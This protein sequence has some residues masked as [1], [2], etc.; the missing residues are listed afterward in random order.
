[1]LIYRP[2]D[3]GCGCERSSESPCVAVVVAGSPRVQNKTLAALFLQVGHQL[4]EAR[5]PYRL[6]VATPGVDPTPQ[7]RRSKLGSSRPSSRTGHGFEVQP[8]ILR[9]P[10]A[11]QRS[12]G[13]QLVG[14][15]DCG[16][17][18][19]GASGGLVNKGMHRHGGI[20]TDPVYVK[21]CNLKKT[22]HD[23]FLGQD[24][25]DG[26]ALGEEREQRLRRFPFSGCTRS[27]IP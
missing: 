12:G 17:Q 23:M 9:T 3:A 5:L 11:L 10:Q 20:L 6:R 1:M 15:Q 22:G 26:L 27:N 18:Q 8:S 21:S 13:R 19:I 24:L 25:R 4:T 7:L 16:G 14:R 2:G